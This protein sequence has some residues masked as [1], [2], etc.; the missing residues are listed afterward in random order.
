MANM[1]MNRSHSEHELNEEHDSSHEYNEKHS[2][3]SVVVVG[4]GQT[5]GLAKVEA[6]QR[7]WGP[8]SRIVFWIGIA[9]ISYVYSLDGETTYTY[10]TYA[11]SSFNQHS[12][13]G[14][15]ATAQAI[16]LACMKPVAAK[17]A[18]TFGRAEAFTFLVFFYC[19]G[20]I[21][22]ASCTSINTYAAGGI[23]YYV[24]YSC[25]EILIQ[26]IIGDVTNLRWRSLLSSLYSLPFLVNWAVASN[27]SADVLAQSGWR[28]GYGM[29]AIIVPA[30]VAPITITLYWAQHR[31]KK[32]GVVATN[33][34]DA[35]GESDA[36]RIVSNQPFLRKFWNFLVDMDALGLLIFAA[37]WACLLVP[38][39]LVNGAYTTWNSPSI[40]AMLVCGGVI[41]LA[42]IPYEAYVAKIP[43]FP[44]AFFRNPTILFPAFIGFFDFVSFYLQYTYQYSFIFVT[45]DW[46]TV[47]Q[48]YFAYT[49][50]LSLTVFGILTGFVQAYTR[51][52]KWLL[53]IGLCIRLL[54]VG[55]MIKSKG[56]HGTTGFLV[57]C[58]VLQGLGGGIAACS[59]QLLAQGSVRHQDL[60]TATAFVLL[61]AAIGNAVGS[62]LAAAIWRDHM[63]KQLSQ[64]L[65]GLLN[66]TEIDSIYASIT[67]AVT[68]RSDEAVYDGIITSYDYTMKILLIVATA[69]AVVPVILSF[70][71]KDM[72]LSDKHNDVEDIDAN[73][74]AA[75]LEKA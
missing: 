33:I 40:I 35:T 20:Y 21:L 73:G 58:Q 74:T 7:V 28:W 38:L 50:T 8:K 37:G 56:A 3:A 24:G 60:G 51:R 36:P 12:L 63:P 45:K 67:T 34:N 11:T 64:N 47:D 17:I 53:T 52:T 54:G 23:I 6:V 18:D 13:L 19:L 29:F 59:S 69:I 5:E 42:F 48:N 9:L 46:S 71:V 4:E 31:A 25:L 27:I 2:A 10:Q 55:L 41:L 66:S 14:A 62:A 72:Y 22:L 1:T 68:Y 15:I 70:F 57:I 49:Q 39:T 16:I 30:A 75:D 43:V 32:L 44:L 65:N 26:I 61:W